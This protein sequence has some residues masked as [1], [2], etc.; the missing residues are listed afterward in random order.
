MAGNN[1][2]SNSN[3]NGTINE[4]APNGLS[5]A[6][7]EALPGSSASPGGA[8]R[9]AKVAVTFMTRD[10]DAE[11]IVDTG[12]ILAAM[13]GNKAF[14][15]PVPALAD[16]IAARNAYIAAVNAGHDSRV[17]RSLRDKARQEFTFLLRQLAE[18]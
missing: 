18:G 14:P 12:R 13:A 7:R 8:G 16:L 2:N 9:P 4:A 5:V 6:I 3:N 1:S 15:T 10:T 17:A 11:Y